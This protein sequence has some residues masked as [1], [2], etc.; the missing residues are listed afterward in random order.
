MARLATRVF[1]ALPPRAQ[2]NAQELVA[3]LGDRL[4]WQAWREAV[5]HAQMHAGMLVCGDFRTAAENIL[6]GAPA[7]V[8]R[9]PSAA[10]ASYPPLRAL[11][12]FAVSEEYLLLR[13]Q[14]VRHD[15]W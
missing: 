12:R 5:A 14:R 1:E 3:Q 10:L 11:A 15:R 8:P 6:M 2:R 4:S 13:W 7:G 9:E